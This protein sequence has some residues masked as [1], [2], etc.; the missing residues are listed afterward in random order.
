MTR[1][2]VAAPLVLLLGFGGLGLIQLYDGTKPSFER[3]TRQAPAQTFSL[4]DGGESDFRT[5]A[6]DAPIIVNL[7]A[8]WCAPCRVEHP[9][10]IELGNQYP[11]RLHGVLYDDTASNGRGFLEELGNPF[12][13]IALDESGQLG[14]DFG[15]TGVPET[16]V[17][18]PGGEITLHIRGQLTQSHL[19]VI[20]QEM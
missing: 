7:W 2:L 15:H 6:A 17:I 16:F 13:S 20:A 3:V 12:S 9:L 10:L 1:L 5:L 8:S 11:D 4:L 14:L 18:Q 19:A